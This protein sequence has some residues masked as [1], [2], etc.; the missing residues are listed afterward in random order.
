MMSLAPATAP[1]G[2]PVI[3]RRAEGRGPELLSTVR[4]P[5]RRHP[6]ICRLFFAALPAAATRPEVE[7][8]QEVSP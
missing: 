1:G 6:E 3:D 7:V 2:T 5:G 8:S 4:I